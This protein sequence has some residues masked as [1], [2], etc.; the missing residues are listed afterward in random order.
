VESDARFT[1]PGI[2]EAT[3]DGMSD[4]VAVSDLTGRF[5]V[6]NE[7][8][9]RILGIGPVRSSPEAW[10]ED[11]G[12]FLPDGSTPF[13][14][15]DLP[16][17]RALRGESADQ[18]EM[19]VRNRHVPQGL[20]IS[21]STRP[22]TDDDD[23][24]FGAVA[25][26]RD[27]TARRRI[28]D[29]MRVRDRALAAVDEGVLITDPSRPDNPVI[30][31]N[32]AITRITGYPREEIVGRNCR[33]LQGTDRDQEARETLRDAVAREVPC[34]VLI[35]NYRRDGEMFWN[36]LSLSPVRDAAGRT[37]HFVGVLHDATERV[38]LQEARE[39]YERAL[40]SLAVRVV[41]A[42]EGERRRIATELHDELAQKL[43]FALMTMSEL[44]GATTP[45]GRPALDRLETMLREAVEQVRSLIFELSPPVLYDLGFGAAIEWLA[46]RTEARHGVR[47]RVVNEDG[48]ELGED[49]AIL[50]FQ[51]VR[52]LLQNA[53]KHAD[54]DRVEVRLAPDGED[55]VRVEV[56]DDGRGFERDRLEQALSGDSCFGLFN[57]RERLRDLG[58]SCEFPEPDG[59][60]ARIVLRSPAGRPAAIDPVPVPD[61]PPSSSRGSRPIP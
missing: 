38:R 58:G 45:E 48:P 50:L 31:C 13:P 59:A 47:C 1:H 3:L 21:V 11:Y 15:D 43:A 49:V 19:F 28:E 27:I 12:L 23:R 44:G 10:S 41:R 61:S 42:E 25:V 57:I 36:E 2:L 53:V 4:G 35:R 54:A 52:E 8:A 32:E 55:G 16:L 34:R 9:R 56:S 17:V 40:Q 33:F 18:V 7:P 39:Q 14:P 20:A 26:F 5:L 60:G 37:T 22:L 29:A 51:A 6:F 30:H 24:P 46:E